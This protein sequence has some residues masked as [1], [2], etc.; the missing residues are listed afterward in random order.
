MAGA[1]GET[2]WI[3]ACHQQPLSH[4]SP[5]AN[6]GAPH[7]HWLAAGGAG[8]AQA[9]SVCATAVRDGAQAAKAWNRCKLAPDCKTLQQQ[10]D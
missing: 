2:G 6:A 10:H 9:R 7:A 3:A 1:G 4:L 5:R 8:D